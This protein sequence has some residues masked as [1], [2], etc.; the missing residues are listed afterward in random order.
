MSQRFFGFV[1]VL[2]L[3]AGVVLLGVNFDPQSIADGMVSSVARGNVAEPTQ[4]LAE[5]CARHGMER[6]DWTSRDS[7]EFIEF[8]QS[9]RV[10]R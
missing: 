4:E 1:V 10:S 2:L 6:Y 3:F 5:Y 9:V 8:M 7:V